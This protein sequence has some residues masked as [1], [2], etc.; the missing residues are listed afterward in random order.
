MGSTSRRALSYVGEGAE[1]FLR[2]GGKASPLAGT[3]LDICVVV[4]R[5]YT[6][7]ELNWQGEMTPCNAAV[8][9]AGNTQ[10]LLT[11]KR[12]LGSGLKAFTDLGIEPD[13]KI[14]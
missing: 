1:V 4:E 7:E 6:A 13:K 12:V 11:A 9:R 2:V 3:P 5:I 14:A 8:I 10:L